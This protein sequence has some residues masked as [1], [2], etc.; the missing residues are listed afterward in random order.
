MSTIA[1][2]ASASSP[3]IMG[4]PNV[5]VMYR[6]TAIHV[7]VMVMNAMFPVIVLICVLVFLYGFSIAVRF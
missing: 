5:R 3:A 1:W 6:N 4:V 7:M 2:L